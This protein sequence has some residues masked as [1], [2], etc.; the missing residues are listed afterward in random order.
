M[1]LLKALIWRCCSVLTLQR[2]SDFIKLLHGNTLSWHHHQSNSRL[3]KVV[4]LPS[5]IIYVLSCPKLYSK[6]KLTAVT[7]M[8]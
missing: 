3:I 4:Q 5:K 1:C 6:L 7:S 2:V 8:G